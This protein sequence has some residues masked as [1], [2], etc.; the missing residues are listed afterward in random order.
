MAVTAVQVVLEVQQK[1]VTAV[2]AA[3]EAMEVL[4]VTAEVA[5]RQTAGLVAL[6]VKDLILE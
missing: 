4:L 2:L 1:V 3:L 6:T 5:A